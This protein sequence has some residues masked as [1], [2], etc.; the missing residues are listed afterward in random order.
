MV[1]TT[2]MRPRGVVFALLFLACNGSP[3]EPGSIPARGATIVL[4]AGTSSQVSSD[5]RVSFSQVIE[6]SRCPASVQ[7]AWEGNGAIRLDVTT[8]NGVQSIT[9]NTASGTAF[10]HEASVGGYTFTLEQLNPQRQTADP[11]PMQ[12]YRATIRVRRA[13]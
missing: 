13:Q 11:V 8:G 12:Q 9:L 4:Q 5:V 2:E 7:C 3:T 10:P 1:L 6:D